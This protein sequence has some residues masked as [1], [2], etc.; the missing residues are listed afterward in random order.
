MSRAK[1]QG[2]DVTGKIEAR[3]DD[4]EA[5]AEKD[6]PCSRIAQALLEISEEHGGNV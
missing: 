3:L 5:L 4:L 2:K 1:Q 6:L